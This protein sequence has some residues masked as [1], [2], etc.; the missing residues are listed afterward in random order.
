VHTLQQHSHWSHPKPRS[1]EM[2]ESQWATIKSSPS[3]FQPFQ[4]NLHYRVIP[5]REGNLKGIIQNLL[6][7]FVVLS[8]LDK[9]NCL[10]LLSTNFKKITSGSNTSPPSRLPPIVMLN[11]P[12]CT[13]SL[14][15]S[16]Y[17]ITYNV[18]NCCLHLHV[19]SLPVFTLI[20]SGSL[21]CHVSMM[22]HNKRVTLK[23]GFDIVRP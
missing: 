13:Q 6:L 5:N 15:T 17:L 7:F 21:Q 18:I 14:N 3:L 22:I 23:P 20:L 8:L 12:A 2:Y 16:K 4:Y 11:G 1:Q 10:N 9:Q 19:L